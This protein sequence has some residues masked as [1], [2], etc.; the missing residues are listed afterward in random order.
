MGDVEGSVETVGIRSTRIRTFYNSEIIVP[1]SMLTTAVGDNMGR[2]H[3]RRIKTML[4]VQYDTTPDQ[5]DAFCEGVR[6]LIHRHPHTR[7]DYF[8]VYLNQFSASSL[9]ILLYC[10]LECPD[11]GVELRERH[12]LFADILRL[13]DGLGVQFAFP[14]RTLHIFQETARSRNRS[15]PASERQRR[16]LVPPCGG[17]NNRSTTAG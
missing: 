12:R 10:F 13:A 2:R 3:Y 4:G 16:M 1:N 6:E 17:T 9:D 8:H 7:K 14:T 5:I 15:T 11:W